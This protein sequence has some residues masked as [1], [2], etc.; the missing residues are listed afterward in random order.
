M[1]NAL[2]RYRAEQE[3]EAKVSELQKLTDLMVNRELDMA[4]MKER[5]EKHT[6]KHI[7]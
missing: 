1:G 2:A 6:T 4:K 3:L 5:Y 7:A